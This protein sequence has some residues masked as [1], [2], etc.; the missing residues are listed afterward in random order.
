MYAIGNITLTGMTGNYRIKCNP[1][2]TFCTIV[3]QTGANI[4][5]TNLGAAT[6]NLIANIIIIP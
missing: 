5:V 3:D 6:K 1:N 2:S 4:T